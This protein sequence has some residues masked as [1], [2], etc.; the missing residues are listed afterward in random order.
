M[1]KFLSAPFELLAEMAD[2]AAAFCNAHPYA[3]IV[4]GL[5]AVAAGIMAWRKAGR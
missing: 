2:K 4:I 3:V 5:A 1:P